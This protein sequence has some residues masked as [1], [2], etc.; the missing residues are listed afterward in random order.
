MNLVGS[1][2]VLRAKICLAA[3]ELEPSDS[4]TGSRRCR[5]PLAAAI[6]L[7]VSLTSS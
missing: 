3:E 6:L 2:V 1:Y 7:S 4:L 5:E